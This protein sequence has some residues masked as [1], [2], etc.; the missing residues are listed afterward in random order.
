M[1]YSIA[2][3][4]A[5]T[6]EFGAAIAT[7]MPAVGALC[8]WTRSDV[9]V[10]C[11][12]SWTNPHLGIFALDAMAGGLGAV[13]AGRKALQGDQGAARRQLGVVG[14]GGT[15]FCFTGTECT[16][17]CGHI[18]GPDFATQGNMLTSAEVVQALAFS[19]EQSSDKPLDERLLRALESAQRAGGDKRGRQSAA[20]AVIG[21]D[22]FRSVDLRVDEHADPVSELRRVHGIAR[23]Q[24]GP[25]REWLPDKTGLAPDLPVDVV[26]M[27]LGAPTARPRGGGSEDP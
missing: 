25:L 9:G 16:G 14:N 10:V 17:W 2:G 11:T 3:R 26:N 12:Q 27:V 4:C 6:G 21:A 7:A 18:A 5:R 13:E 22:P 15:G 1:T 20:L 24:L 8:V 19:F 23:A